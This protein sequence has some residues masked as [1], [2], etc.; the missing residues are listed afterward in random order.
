[1]GGEVDGLPPLRGQYFELNVVRGLPQEVFFASKSHF[2]HAET[3][4]D[5]D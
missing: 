2:S 3:A 4:K 5:F 1:M